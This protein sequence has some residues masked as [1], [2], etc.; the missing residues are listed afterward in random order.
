MSE[1]ETGETYLRIRISLKRHLLTF[2]QTVQIDWDD[3]FKRAGC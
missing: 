1:Q 2:A 3:I